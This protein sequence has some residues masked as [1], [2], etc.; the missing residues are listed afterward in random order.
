M[1]KL[2]VV[3]D[4]P[5]PVTPMDHLDAAVAKAKADGATIFALVYQTA[6][7]PIKTVSYPP[8]ILFQQAFT[9]A[10]HDQ[11]TDLNGG[12]TFIIEGQE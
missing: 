3:G 5:L 8:A 10:A 6:D 9:G 2:N 11:I 1:R 4:A 7:E 12:P